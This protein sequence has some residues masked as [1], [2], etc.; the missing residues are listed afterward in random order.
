MPEVVTS[1]Q[2][3]AIA[4][5]SAAGNF[6]TK[7]LDV[8]CSAASG[9]MNMPAWNKCAREELRREDFEGEPC[10]IGLD[11]G[12]KSDMTAKVLMFPREDRDGRTYFVTFADFYLP[13]ERLRRH[14]TVSTGAGSSKGLYALLM[15]L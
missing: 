15:A 7:H 12:S 9:W 8:W 1:L 10:Y 14:L 6:M 5:P 11:L 2:K 4:I 13:P 3:K